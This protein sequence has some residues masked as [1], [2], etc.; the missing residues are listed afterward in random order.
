MVRIR[1][2]KTG[3]RNQPRWRVGVFDQRTRRDGRAIEYLGY[4]DQHAENEEDKLSV[5]PERVR[6]WLAKGA[7]PTQTVRNLLKQCGIVE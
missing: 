5:D 6:H 7:Q 1:L 4:Y 3:R 2:T